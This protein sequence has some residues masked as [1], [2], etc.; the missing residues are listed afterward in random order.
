MKL[1]YYLCAIGD[2]NFDIKKNIFFANIKN[3]YTEFNEKID[4][5]V[6]IYTKD[7]CFEENIKN[8]PYIGK[9]YIYNKK[10]IMPEL[11]LTNPYNKHFEK[12]DYIIFLV[13]DISL[14][15]G[16]IKNMIDV[17]NKYNLD[18]I[19]PSVID[20]TH[21][22]MRLFEANKLQF[23]NAIE[24]YFYLVT[25]R[26]LF[27]MFEF[28]DVDNSLLWGYDF[29]LGYFG[30]NCAIYSN[31]ICKHHLRQRNDPLIKHISG[32]ELMIKFIKKNGF[33]SIEDVQK[34]YPSTINRITI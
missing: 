4:V 17:K 19:S 28:H 13:D 31:V 5:N 18:I 23:A 32:Y 21:D 12:Y 30:F 10:G 11:F 33:N 6:N 26:T 1:L 22:F 3:I 7:N 14:E 9:Y 20:A 29:L 15:K 34:K 8:S 25:P 16:S 24:F 2:Y 27:Q